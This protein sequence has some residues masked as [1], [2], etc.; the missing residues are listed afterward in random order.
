[1]SQIKIGDFVTGYGSGY[2]QPIDIK[3]HLQQKTI[4]KHKNTLNIIKGR[5]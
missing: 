3:P 2:R 4:T 1:M 5:N